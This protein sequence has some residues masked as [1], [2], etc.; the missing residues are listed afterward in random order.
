MHLCF[1]FF[2]FFKQ[3]V[4]LIPC[5]Y[6]LHGD[7]SSS[8]AQGQCGSVRA[9]TVAQPRKAEQQNQRG[10]VKSG[11]RYLLYVFLGKWLSD[12]ADQPLC[13]QRL[14]NGRLIVSERVESAEQLQ[15]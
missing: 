9:S 3:K 15:A 14:G 2:L 4:K 12:H 13:V 1:C 8:G 6:H 5:Y 10:P 11:G 7:I